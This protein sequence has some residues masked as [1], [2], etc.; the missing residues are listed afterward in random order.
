M[1]IT[2]LIGWGTFIAFMTLLIWI[3]IKKA[4]REETYIG[5]KIIGYYLLGTFTFRM[6]SW[7]LPA[8]FVI[9]LLF[10]RPR[11]YVNRQVKK[12]AAIAGVLSFLSGILITQFEE[13][14]HEKS[15]VFHASSTNVFHMKLNEEYEM[16]KSAIEAEGELV[17]SNFDLQFT[18]SG[19][20]VKLSYVGYFTKD[21]RDMIA[22]VEQRNGT[23]KINLQILHE[24]SDRLVYQ[25]TISSPSIYFK[26]ID[27]HG[28]KKMVPNSDR[29]FVSFS[30]S[31][32]HNEAADSNEDESFWDIQKSGIKEYTFE[33]VSDDMDSE[34]NFSYHINIASMKLMG[35]DS[36]TA[37]HQSFFHI[38]NTLYQ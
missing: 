7:V 3:Y 2:S 25:N 23:Y 15:I 32:N 29:Y 20:V 14:Y 26:A 34:S 27:L 11:L 30:N 9:F 19:K 18:K 10:F 33:T 4:D 31:S 35:A 5:W 8:G 28:L 12:W 22:W 16:V 13:A 24:E 37:H 36:Y 17:I 21:G 6:D 1:W 38:S